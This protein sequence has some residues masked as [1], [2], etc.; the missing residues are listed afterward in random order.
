[1]R[2]LQV[3]GDNQA[4]V[5]DT[6]LSSPPAGW[7]AVE[8]EWAAICGTDRKMARRGAHLGMTLGHEI[9]G[10][11]T[12]GRA[13]AVHPDVGCGSCHWC[14]RGWSNRCSSKISIGVDVDGGIAERVLVPPAHIVPVDGID[15][16]SAPML[17]PLACCLHAIAVAEAQTAQSAVV[18]GAG[19]MGILMMW[20]L[21]AN[22][23]RVTVIQRSEPR[24]QL[25]LDLG[26]DEV[27]ESL[28]SA[29]VDAIF[30]SVPGAEALE[31]ALTAVRVGG[32][33]HAFA[34]SPG[35]APVDANLLHYRHLRLVGSTGSGLADF[36]HA[37]DLQKSGRVDV[38]RLPAVEVSIEES[39]RALLS[40]PDPLAMRTLVR[41]A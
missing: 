23:T 12:T 35:G 14:H 16:R 11:D 9:A 24:R 21:Q 3:I 33:V 40:D 5:V 15:T 30:V 13:V 18:V 31:D 7:E 17:E 28:Q 19:A 6:R 29:E 2:A 20:A 22:G 27:H 4:A 25:A 39:A 10:R 26:A 8:V 38:G 36:R 34:G 1:M 37:V 41:I 32:S